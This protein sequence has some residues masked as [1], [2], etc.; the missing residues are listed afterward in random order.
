MAGHLVA[1]AANSVAKAAAAARF[2]AAAA[3]FERAT[4]IRFESG[5][6]RRSSLWRAARVASC[7]SAMARS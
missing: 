5:S 6:E 2:A 7:A 1:G 3:P 4:V